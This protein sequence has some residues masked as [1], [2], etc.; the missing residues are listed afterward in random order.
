MPGWIW[1]LLVVF[2]LIV[3]VCGIAYAIVRAKHAIEAVHPLAARFGHDMAAIQEAQDEPAPERKPIVM[4]RSL[5]DAQQDYEDAHAALVSHK[6]ERKA[7]RDAQRWP[8]G[9][10]FGTPAEQKDDPQVRR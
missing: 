7:A 4:A 2:L 6:I 1:I 8:R 10:A 3:L 5:S 9:A